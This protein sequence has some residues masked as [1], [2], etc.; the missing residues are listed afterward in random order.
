MIKFYIGIT[1]AA[2]FIIFGAIF[3][4]RL[5]N[6]VEIRIRNWF[7]EHERLKACIKSMKKILYKILITIFWLWITISVGAAILDGAYKYYLNYKSPHQRRLEFLES[8]CWQ[9]DIGYEILNN[10]KSTYKCPNGKEYQV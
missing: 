4:Y 5:S 10:G 1:L 3:I 6:R 2:L 7:D 8:N 9:I